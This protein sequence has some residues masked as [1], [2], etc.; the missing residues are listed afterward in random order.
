M[1]LGM[2]PESMAV[3]KNAWG[4]I[5]DQVVVQRIG[6][7]AYDVS[8]QFT[9]RFRY[10]QLTA[11]LFERAIR[12]AVYSL[13][14]TIEK[15]VIVPTPNVTTPPLQCMSGVT[16]HVSHNMPDGMV[17]ISPKTYYEMLNKVRL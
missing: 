8:V 9:S 3:I 12:S 5:A 6:E 10:H 11:E 7:D 13:C 14:N 15:A 1:S 16:F 17:Y 4:D 2:A